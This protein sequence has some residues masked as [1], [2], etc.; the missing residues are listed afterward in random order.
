MIGSHFPFRHFG[1]QYWIGQKRWK[2]DGSSTERRKETFHSF[3]SFR[4]RFCWFCKKKK[5]KSRKA[6]DSPATNVTL[7]YLQSWCYTLRETMARTK[8]ANRKVTTEVGRLLLASVCASISISWLSLLCFCFCR[9]CNEGLSDH[10]KRLLNLSAQANL[11]ICIFSVQYPRKI[12]C[13]VWE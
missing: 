7:W 9:L 10:S 3:L 5:K 1:L 6:V 8:L 2:L 11:P 4:V 12:R 13:L